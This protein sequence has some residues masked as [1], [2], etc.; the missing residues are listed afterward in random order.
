MTSHMSR[1]CGY[2]SYFGVLWVSPIL[3]LPS[4]W[5][6]VCHVCVGYAWF[7]LLGPLGLRCSHAALHMVPRVSLLCGLCMVRTLGSCGSTPIL[8]LQS[9]WHYLRQ[10][11]VDYARFV[12]LDPLGLPYSLSPVQMSPLP[13]R[14]CGLCMVRTFGSFGS[15]LL[16]FSRPDVTAS[17][18]S[19]WIMVRAGRSSGSPY[20]HSP[21]RSPP[22]PHPSKQT[23]APPPLTPRLLIPA[24]A[25]PF[26]RFQTSFGCSFEKVSI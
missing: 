15:P 21:V 13:S 25:S 6:R 22:P 18:T 23:T 4:I 24:I 14:L 1:L 10:V 11:C 8:C 9:T 2:S 17:I 7:V 3:M 5:Y 16:S 12:L 26:D 19:V 20:S